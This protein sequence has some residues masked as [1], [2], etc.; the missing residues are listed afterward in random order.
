MNAAASTGTPSGRAH[1]QTVRN[2]DSGA[3][4][5]RPRSPAKHTSRKIAANSTGESV[6]RMRWLALWMRSATRAV[7]AIRSRI[8]RTSRSGRTRSST[9]AGSE[10]V[11]MKALAGQPP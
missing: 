6:R 10:D 7:T 3:A 2:S 5:R 11:I 1:I 4:L 9:S 8:S